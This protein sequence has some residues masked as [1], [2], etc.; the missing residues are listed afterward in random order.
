MF[1][2]DAD[3][4]TNYPNKR[5]D[6][7]RERYLERQYS[8]PEDADRTIEHQYMMKRQL[9]SDTITSNHMSGKLVEDMNNFHMNNNK[10]VLDGEMQGKMSSFADLTKFRAPEQSG[11]QLVYMQ[12]GKEDNSMIGNNFNRFQSDIDKKMTSFGASPN[13]TTWQQQSLQNDQHMSK[14][15]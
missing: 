15:I 8:K 6:D 9:S 4:V 3:T 7:S 1:Y 13:T 5:V 12:H 14:S 2:N 11:I 10:D